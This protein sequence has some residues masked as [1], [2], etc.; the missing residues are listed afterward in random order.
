MKQTI[1][2]VSIGVLWIFASSFKDVSCMTAGALSHPTIV[3]KARTR[4]GKIVTVDDNREAYWWLRDDTPKDAGVLAWWDCGY[5]I[6]AI[7]N[8]TT[9]ADGNT[10][11]HEHINWSFGE[12]SHV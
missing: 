2:F 7:A 3:A 9:I 12:S 8:Q 4:E 10:W 11:N 6:T 5:Q 1:A